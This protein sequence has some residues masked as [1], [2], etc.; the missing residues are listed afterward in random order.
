MQHLILLNRCVLT[1]GFVARY[2]GFKGANEPGIKWRRIESWQ[3]LT[4]LGHPGSALSWSTTMK[5]LAH[6]AVRQRPRRYVQPSDGRTIWS[7]RLRSKQSWRVALLESV[8]TVR[9]VFLSPVQ[10]SSLSIAATSGHEGR[11]SELHTAARASAISAI[12]GASGSTAGPTP[13]GGR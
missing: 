3:M 1:V 9:G 7:T 5:P 8:E 4:A 13:F 12:L 10:V 6:R 2:C 11:N